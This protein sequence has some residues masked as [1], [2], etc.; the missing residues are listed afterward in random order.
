MLAEESSRGGVVAA[1]IGRPD[2]DKVS[3][4]LA[5]KG[6]RAGGSGNFT[7]AAGDALTSTGDARWKR[8]S[9]ATG[10]SVNLSL[11]APGLPEG[12]IS[13]LL[14]AP[15]TLERRGDA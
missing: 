6:D 9:G 10:I 4:K 1:L 13:R 3:L 8:D 12:P 14:R 11:V 7:A 5:I 2:L 15:A